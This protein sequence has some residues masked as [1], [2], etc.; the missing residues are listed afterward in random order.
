MWVDEVEIQVRG[1]DGGHGCLSFRREKYIPRGGPDGGDG[2]RGGA[3]YLE[4]SGRVRTLLDFRFHPEFH[5]PRGGHGEGKK[6]HGRDGEDLILKVPLGTVVF[7]ESGDR[8]ADLQRPGERFLAAKGG[9]GGMG[10]AAFSTATRRAPR[11]A[12]RGEPG[13]SRRLKL[14]LKLLADV[15]VIGMP[16]AGKSTFLAA[17]T[18]ARPKIADYPFTTL[19]PNMGVLRLDGE[20][21]LVLADLP[22]LIEGA[23]SGKGLGFQFLR[24]VERTRVLLHLVDAGG[25]D[26]AKELQKQV[27]IIEKELSGYH[28]SLLQKKRLLVLTK[29]DAVEKEKADRLRKE[30]EAFYRKPVFFISSVTGEG[31]RDLQEAAWRAFQEALTESPGKEP[32]GEQVYT[33]SEP[34]FTVERRAEGFWVDGP[35]IRKW[36]H[37]LDLEQAGARERLEKILMKM[38]VFKELRRLGV[39]S[40]DTLYCAGRPLVYHEKRK[41]A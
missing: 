36:T 1:G 10:N 12:E 18:K 24:H 6:K 23:S 17:V 32:E 27:S 3:V 40:G 34:R 28:A 37:M 20:R 41:R 19:H 4:A 39:R 30:L 31:I 9:R 7:S 29:K 13:E 38:G 16:N 25:A 35:E 33:V 26:S 14:V 8:L 5:A 2:G 22:G 21:T 15:G 11:L